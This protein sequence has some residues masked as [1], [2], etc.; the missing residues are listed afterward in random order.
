[1]CFRSV[2]FLS[3]VCESNRENNL[4]NPFMQHIERTFLMLVH[5]IESKPE[6]LGL[7]HEM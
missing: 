4:Q 3:S 6:S 2:E 5:Y 1:M 7:I